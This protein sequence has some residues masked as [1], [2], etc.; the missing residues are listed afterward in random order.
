MDARI[1]NFLGLPEDEEDFPVHDFLSEPRDGKEECPAIN[2]DNYNDDV[3]FDLTTLRRRSVPTEASVVQPPEASEDSGALLRGGRLGEGGC[4][5]GEDGI[6]S[7]GWSGGFPSQFLSTHPPSTSFVGPGLDTTIGRKGFAREL[8]DDPLSWTSLSLSLGRSDDDRLQS[9]GTDVEVVRGRRKEKPAE[10]VLQGGGRKE[11]SGLRV[12]PYNMEWIG[13]GGGGGGGKEQPAEDVL[14]GGGR[15]EKS[16]L[17]VSPYEME[18]IGGGGGG[19][20]KEKPAEDVLQRGGRKEKPVLRVGP[21]QERRDDSETVVEEGDGLVM[22]EGG[23]KK[24]RHRTLRVGLPA[25]LLSCSEGREESAAARPLSCSDEREEGAAARPLSCSEGREEVAVKECVYPPKG[26]EENGERKRVFADTI[27]IEADD[28]GDDD[29]GYGSGVMR[30]PVEGTGR[31]RS[32]C[33]MEERSSGDLP[34]NEMAPE[35]RKRKPVLRVGIPHSVEPAEKRRSLEGKGKKDGASFSRHEQ[36]NMV[37]VLDDSDCEAHEKGGRG[38]VERNEK[39]G[40]GDRDKDSSLAFC[41][42]EKDTTVLSATEAMAF[43]M[44]ARKLEKSGSNKLPRSQEVASEQNACRV[45]GKQS[46]CT[47]VDLKKTKCSIPPGKLQNSGKENS[48]VEEKAAENIGLK[49]REVEEEEEVVQSQERREEPFS[50]AEEKAA[51]KVGQNKRE[52][53]EKP[54]GRAGE[55]AAEKIVRK[56]REGEEEEE[57]AQNQEM[58]KPLKG[59]E[60]QGKIKT[61]HNTM[62]KKRCHSEVK[63]MREPQRTDKERFHRLRC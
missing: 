30:E 52:G 14:Q 34:K 41:S 3:A 38:G 5:S 29:R 53:A 61:A 17:R 31:I 23:R 36:S 46:V 11:K 42:E 22:C 6:V 2:I 37:I 43:E 39:S 13:G 7:A 12:S 56:K 35:G 51:V 4:R 1:I 59:T 20:R 40:G 50:R 16:G 63:V 58:E 55:K 26:S 54:F 49:T 18:W 10:D 32:G 57:I 48:R 19:G 25:R 9:R 47:D 21:T 15:K 44:K 60:L 62:A 45:G 8:T 24:Q 33:C 27:V 28:E